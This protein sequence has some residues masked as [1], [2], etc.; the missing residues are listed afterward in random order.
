MVTVTVH[1]HWS[2]SRSAWGVCEVFPFLVPL[3]LAELHVAWAHI[4][5]A[6]PQ[7]SLP[8]CPSLQHRT[9][10]QQPSRGV[11]SC[12]ARDVNRRQIRTPWPPSRCDMEDY[13]KMAQGFCC[14]DCRCKRIDLWQLLLTL[15][16][17]GSSD[18]FS[19]SE[20]EF[21]FPIPTTSVWKYHWTLFVNLSSSD[22]LVKRC[23]F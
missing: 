4:R 7:H 8:L 17:A 6:R 14:V 3:S 12:P 20:G 22:D 2:L 5:A 9:T 10:M 1:S 21:C 13:R 15:A 18:A 23:E 19:G 11:V 16:V